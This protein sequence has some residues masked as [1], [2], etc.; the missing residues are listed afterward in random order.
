MKTVANGIFISKLRYCLAL[1]APVRLKKDDPES[2]ALA[3][4]KVTYNKLLRLLTKTSINEKRS[5]KSMLKDLNWPSV[6]QMIAEVR[7]VEAWKIVNDKSSP[8]LN[9]IDLKENFTN[10]VTR[11]Q[12]HVVMNPGKP[13]R[14]A[15]NSFAAPTAL[16]WNRAPNNIKEA[17]TVSKAKMLIKQYAKSLPL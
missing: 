14:L 6:N 17:K 3:K 4:I 5:I 7:L 1:F 15:M 11:S 10:A 12:K 9:A 13:S 8:L 16:I 2:S